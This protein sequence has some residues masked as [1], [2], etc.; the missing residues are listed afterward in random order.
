[1]EELIMTKFKKRLSLAAVSSLFALAPAA[2]AATNTFDGNTFTVDYGV[3]AVGPTS[4]FFSLS[5]EDATGSASAVEIPNLSGWKVDTAGNNLSLTWNKVDEFMN[6]GS[7]A[8]ICASSPPALPVESLF[9]S[10]TFIQSLIP[11]S[12]K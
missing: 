11:R 4:S 2:Y 8:F 12:L 3:S 7:P 10:M 9:L 5:K 6:S 1:V